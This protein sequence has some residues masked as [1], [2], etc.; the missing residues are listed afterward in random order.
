MYFF[1]NLRCCIGLISAPVAQNFS[2]SDP[3][4][5]IRNY[6]NKFVDL[7]ENLLKN[8]IEETRWIEN[9]NSKIL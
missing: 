5:T 1:C 2:K 7:C 3:K 6:L 9:K 8:W 4:D